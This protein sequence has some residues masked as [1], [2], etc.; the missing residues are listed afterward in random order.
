MPGEFLYNV[1]R[2]KIVSNQNKSGFLCIAISVFICALPMQDCLAHPFHTSLTEMDWNP[3]AR[4][5]EVGLR[6]DAN[7]LESAIRLHCG[8]QS[9]HF[10]IDDQ[11][12]TDLI[13]AYIAERF[14]LSA[15]SNRALEST[16]GAAGSPLIAA[17]STSSASDHG[18][19]SSDDG[20]SHATQ[21]R[22]VS[23]K[24]EV[25][26]SVQLN[27]LGHEVEGSWVWLYFELIGPELDQLT[28]VTNSV[29][30]EINEDQLNILAI[31][32]GKMKY[33]LQTS[34]RRWWAELVATSGKD[35]PAVK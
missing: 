2:P 10:L 35:S 21:E 26:A 28:I 3:Q 19:P 8:G 27:W 31:R 25:A 6:V 14:R 7:D 5:W 17:E 34:A 24:P 18:G 23:S 30:G 12:A 16:A 13:K 1:R 29:L 9:P 4:S 33:S 15:P 11:S 32:R 22:Q 20:D